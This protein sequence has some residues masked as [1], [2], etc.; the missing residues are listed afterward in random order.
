MRLMRLLMRNCNWKLVENNQKTHLLQAMTLLFFA[1]FFVSS[2]SATVVNH[3]SSSSI[4]KHRDL[5]GGAVSCTVCEVVMTGVF[6]T[7]GNNA[8][9]AD[10]AKDITATCDLLPGVLK[11]PCLAIGK[12]FLKLASFIPQTLQREQYTPYALCS[13]LDGMYLL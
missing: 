8:T 6:A 5:V 9:L 13:M 12:L 2:V 3:L 4:V 7:L 11:V 1:L 10:I